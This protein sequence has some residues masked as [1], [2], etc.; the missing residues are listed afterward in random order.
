MIVHDYLRLRFGNF[1]P[2]SDFEYSFPTFL[3]MPMVDLPDAAAR[4]A[5]R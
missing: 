1:P 4:I 2:G 5:R 3:G